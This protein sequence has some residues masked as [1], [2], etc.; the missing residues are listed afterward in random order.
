MLSPTL[1][2]SRLLAVTRQTPPR[3]TVCRPLLV[4]ST[5]CI[6]KTPVKPTKPL[7]RIELE[8]T[9]CWSFDWGNSETVAIG[10]TNGMFYFKS[11]AIYDVLTVR[12]HFIPP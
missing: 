7:L 6:D 4:C 5:I 2:Q 9:C 10:C 1:E 12:A 11:A 8:E 3:Y